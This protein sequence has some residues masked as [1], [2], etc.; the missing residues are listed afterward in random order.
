MQ[1][2][3]NCTKYVSLDFANNLIIQK[4][5]ILPR[6]K[7]WSRKPRPDEFDHWYIRPCLKNTITR[8]ANKVLI[9]S[10][11]VLYSVTLEDFYGFFESLRNFFTT[12][13]ARARTMVHVINPTQWASTEHS[14]TTYSF[15]YL[16][17]YLNL[18][19]HLYKTFISLFLY[20]KSYRT[21]F[22]FDPFSDNSVISISK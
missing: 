12:P 21:A 15:I 7:I 17:L 3:W 16:K 22:F 4:S 2:F 9:T 10:Y 19:T 14:N 11:F 6:Q 5:K 20:L 13:S 8:S 1:R 18:L